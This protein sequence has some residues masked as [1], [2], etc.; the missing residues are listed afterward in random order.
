MIN[1]RR[2]AF[3][4][5]LRTDDGVLIFAWKTGHP[6]AFWFRRV[7]GSKQWT[8]GGQELGSEQFGRGFD[9]ALWLGRRDFVAEYDAAS[10]LIRTWEALSSRMMKIQVEFRRLEEGGKSKEEAGALS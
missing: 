5:M 10:L 4:A 1:P 2:G 7:S 6:R 3:E 9:L 8:F